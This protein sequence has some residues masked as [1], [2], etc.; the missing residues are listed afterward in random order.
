[1]KYDGSIHS[2]CTGKTRY[3]SKGE[4]IVVILHRKRERRVRASHG[5]GNIHAYR[6]LRCKFWHIGGENLR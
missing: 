6:C 1:M 4:A 5:R 2:G 3:V